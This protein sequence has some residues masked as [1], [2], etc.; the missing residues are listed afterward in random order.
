MHGGSLR[1][2]ATLDQN[3]EPGASVAEIFAYEQETRLA[4]PETWLNWGEMVDRKI[5]IVRDVLGTLSE[6]S[7]IWGYGAAGKATMWVNACGM[8]YLEAMVDGS[9]LRAGKFMPGTHT[10]IVFPDELKKNPPDYIFVSAWNYADVI[11]QKEEW[12]KG[13]WITPLPKLAFF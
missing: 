4:N 2:A 7:R 5:S 3:R 12:F 9:P 13:T 6:K 1:I 11:S 8:N 10:P